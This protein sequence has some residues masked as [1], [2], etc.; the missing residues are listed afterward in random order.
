MEHPGGSLSQR[1]RDSKAADGGLSFQG[2]VAGDLNINHTSHSPSGVLHDLPEAAFNAAA[3]QHLPSCLENTRQGLLEQIQKWA[4]GEGEKRVYWL[5]G[6]AGTGKSTVALTIARQYSRKERLGASFFF[7][8]GGGDVASAGKFAITIAAQLAKALP[9]LSRHVNNAVASNPRIYD[10]GLYEQWEKL[11]LEPLSRPGESTPSPSQPLVIVV[12]ALDECDNEDDVSL[13]IQCLAD[14]AAVGKTPLRV[15]ITSRP[16][17]LVNSGFNRISRDAHQD[18]ILHNIE[19]SIVDQDL[20]L[21][22]QSRLTHTA[23]RFGLGACLY[24]DET[25]QILVRK[26]ERLFIHAATVCRFIHDGGQLARERLSLLVNKETQPTQPE[27]ELYKMYTA[28]LE[29]SFAL[30]REPEEAAKIYALFNRVVGSIVVLSDTVTSA[31]LSTILAEPEDNIFP[32]LHSLYSVLDVPEESDRRIRLVHPSFRDFLLDPASSSNKMISVDSNATHRDLLYCCLRLMKENLRRNMCNIEWPGTRARDIPK[33]RIDQLISHPVQYACRN[34]VHHLQQSDVDPNEVLEIMDF[35]HSRFLYWLETLSW[36]G[37]LAEGITM[38]RLLGRKLAPQPAAIDARSMLSRMKS[39]LRHRLRLYSPNTTLSLHE[40]VYD[41]MRFLLSNSWIIEEAP[42][43][44]YCSAILFSPEQS[45]T[46][47]MHINELPRWILQRPITSKHWPSHLQTLIHPKLVETAAFSPDGQF[48]ASAGFENTTAVRLWDAATGI[49]Q[50]PFRGDSGNVQALAF[51]LDNRLIVS[52]GDSIVRFWDVATGKEQRTLCNLP[53]DIYQVALSPNGPLIALAISANMILLCDAATGNQQ[54]ILWGHSDHITAIAFSPDGQLVASGSIDK[55]VRLWSVTT[56]E[57]QHVLRGHSER[58]T[59][60]AFSPDGRL[61]ISTGYDCTIRF[62]DAATGK[63]QRKIKTPWQ[64]NT[65]VCD[66][67]FLPDNRLV[68]LVPSGEKIQL[69]DVATGNKQHMQQDMS[70]KVSHVAFSPASQLV[71]LVDD[72]TMTVQ[73]RN[74]ATGINEH[75]LGGGWGRIDVIALSPNGRLIA[76]TENSMKIRLWDTATGIEQKLLQR[77]LQGY[78]RAINAIAFSPDGR[79]LA[80]AGHDRMIRLWDVATGTE[81]HTLRGYSDRV[82]VVAFSPDGLL[83]ASAGGNRTIRLWDVATGTEKHTLRGHSDWVRVVA[84]SPDGLLLASAG[85]GRAIRLW[86]VATGT[87]QHILRVD[88]V[89]RYM[90]FS[91]CGNGL[92]TNQGLFP[93]SLG[94]PQLSKTITVS[95]LWIQEGGRD[96]LYIHPD[97]RPGLGFVSGNIA[98]FYGPQSST[99]RLDASSSKSMI[100]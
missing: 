51:S 43:Q 19:N 37:R 100:Y 84:F 85:D 12:D 59:A 95:G 88:A 8:R 97:Y 47:R 14:A 73:L 93:L 27:K 25:I 87:E 15:F 5:K 72:H 32:M 82:Q 48:I 79:L 10:V 63:E 41:A 35:F 58:T 24:S 86:D 71:A 6:M 13:L 68:A 65:R 49:E 52:A 92:I 55:E 21:F 66:I 89:P 26:S 77:N 69:W 96:L 98:I 74:A 4:D 22:Y 90:G 3:K 36:I 2:H 80:S 83:I 46:R 29:H 64:G 61:V 23:E 30:Y 38:I 50:R 1:F 57:E 53:F 60:V 40:T 18:F 45:I 39:K 31:E 54:H 20:T 9:E 33:A 56:G 44:T 11:V 7:S 42:L 16:D 28:V 99:L 17:Q 81:K 78:S 67:A 70:F 34:W 76:L 75:I 91:S 62:W 94:E